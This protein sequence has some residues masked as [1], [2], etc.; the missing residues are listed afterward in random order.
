MKDE[1]L[2]IDWF[3]KFQSLIPSLFISV[4]EIGPV[5]QDQQEDDTSLIAEINSLKDQLHTRNIKLLVII[6][7]TAGN[8]TPVEH[9]I[10]RLRKE[11]SLNGRNG[12]LFLSP[13]L[14]SKELNLFALEVLQ[15]VKLASSEFYST[16]DKKLR[17]ERAKAI[18]IS[19][20]ENDGPEKNAIEVKY[21]LKVAFINELKGS[22]EQASKHFETAYENFIDIFNTGYPVVDPNWSHF[23]MLLDMIVFRIVRLNFYLEFPNVAYRKFDIH[24][25]SV[26]Y[27]LKNDGI[28]VDSEVVINW[29]ATQYKWLAQLSDLAPTSLVPTDYPFKF[30]VTVSNR[31]SPL[32]LPHSGFLYLQVVDFLKK[33]QAV[34]DDGDGDHDDDERKDPYFL[35][36]EEN[37]D[38]T[39]LINLLTFAKLAFQK[40]DNTFNRS[41]AYVNYQI[42][43]E[44]FKLKDFEKAFKFYEQTLDSVKEDDWSYLLSFIHF[45]L[46]QCSKELNKVYAS[47]LNLLELALIPENSIE[48]TILSQVKTETDSNSGF[49]QFLNESDEILVI[50]ATTDSTFDLF[51]SKILFQTHEIPLS[52]SVPLQI[53]LNSKLNDILPN[54]KLDD[55]LITFNG[56][57]F[58]SILVKHDDSKPDSSFVKLDDLQYD[59]SSDY[60]VTHTNLNFKSLQRKTIQ[61][62]LPATRQ[63][64][65]NEI[66]S[67]T[68]TLD[69]ESI[70]KVKLN[71]PISANPFDRRHVWFVDE[72]TTRIINA[73]EPAT[74]NVVPRIPETTV[75]IVEDKIPKFAIVGE[76][77]AVKVDVFDED[78]EV[79]DLNVDVDV[80]GDSSIGYKWDDYEKG[81]ERLELKSLEK[82]I[83]HGH[84]LYL[85]IPQDFKN[86]AADD[87]NNNV[88]VKL[89]LTYYI[90]GDYD[91]PSHKYLSFAFSIINPF[92]VN[93]SIEPRLKDLD[94][95][96][97]ISK[98]VVKESTET[99]PNPKP[100]R[101]WLFRLHTFIDLKADV[102]V[103]DEELIVKSENDKVGCFEESEW[104]KTERIDNKLISSHYLETE[105]LDGHTHRNIQLEVL[106]KLK[107]KRVG[108]DVVSA[109][110]NDPWKLTLPLLD[111][112][113][114]L[115]IQKLEGNQLEL[116]FMIENPTSKLFS[117]STGLL[118]NTHFTLL[119]GTKQLPNVSVN[120]LERQLIKFTLALNSEGKTAAAGGGGGGTTWHQ[121]PQLRV[122]DIN[123]R[124]NLPTLPIT[125]SPPTQTHKGEIYLL[126]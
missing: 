12:L 125:D 94:N 22:Y 126:L 69:Y 114:L 97:D 8:T 105:I 54:S 48:P 118:E 91:I 29:L 119:S 76:T 85:F 2:P 115:S 28:D 16:V 81:G 96:Q 50:N 5:P 56:D 102:E 46:F 59:E 44:H 21:C 58:P 4:Y 90:N 36:N 43:E 92:K 78:A 15:I 17:K 7:T 47:V 11:T 61:F 70:F 34:T 23:R 83:H 124:V 75:S 109:Y 100:S 14:K 39:E 64:G 79:I 41:I 40:R 52:S 26:L 80:V 63:I 6:T 106:F 9:R 32:L 53:S 74:I 87:N 93:V 57:S 37:D 68:S 110:V 72:N 73:K 116:T 123:Y 104:K 18:S 71:I 45:K 112:R 25:K 10:E 117:F 35:K 24:L 13:D 66:N 108:S 49:K 62:Q 33:E 111:P 77:L 88:E 31:L 82:R 1:I 67:I 103:V 107:Y 89:K 99:N 51:E 27:F 86:S 101:Y 120:P 60:L 98:L 121:L 19:H 42:A 65:F 38:E 20:A 113:V 30:D 84:K 55:L 122:Y 3:H 95:I